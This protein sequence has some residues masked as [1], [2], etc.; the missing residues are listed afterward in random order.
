MSGVPLIIA[1]V[2]AVILMI[3]SISKWKVHPFLSIMTI[4]LIFAIVAGIPLTD[5]PGV[6]GTGFSNT[7][8]S[9]GIV[10]ILGALIGTLLEKT[11]AALKMADCVVKLV[12]KKR[13]EL[14]MLIMGWIVSIPV[15]CDSGFVVLNPI[16]KALVKRTMKSSVACTVALS[17][18][19]YISHCFIPPTPGPIAAANTIYEGINMDTN[20]LMVMGMGALCSILPLIA[21]YFFAINVGKKVKAQDE[22]GMDNGEVVKSYEELVASFGKLPSAFMSFAPI[23][24]PIVLMGLSSAL[25]MAGKPVDIITFLGTPIIAIAVGVIFGLILLADQKKI[26]EFYEITNDTLKVTGPIL[27][28]TAAGGVLGNVIA[29]SSMVEY[30][31]SNST[32]LSTFGLM[33][34]FLLSA[35]LKTAQGS[36]TVALTTTAG[37]VAPML[38][39]LGL[40]T[41]PL[42]A[43]TVIAIGAGAMT[44]SHANDSYFWVVTNFGQMKVEDGY[45]TQTLGT[46]IAGIASIINVYLVYFFIR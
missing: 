39:T 18:G 12:G 17:L 27:F 41:S 6:I 40:A 38:E 23:I 26:G 44:V 36:S 20:M 37:I 1:F 14:A 5:I 9:I 8:K 33:F 2:I 4:S 19:L 16:R 13:P 34:P 7:F 15:F 42:A 24:V 28:I 46:L 31:K 32:A 21:S 10:I 11:G 22:A 43:L 29:S 3:I 45:K 30:I 35:I 25:S